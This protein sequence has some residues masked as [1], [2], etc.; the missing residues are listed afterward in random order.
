MGELVLDGRKELLDKRGE[1]EMVAE[2]DY[3]LLRRNPRS[4]ASRLVI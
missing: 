1:E 2:T 3:G 4:L